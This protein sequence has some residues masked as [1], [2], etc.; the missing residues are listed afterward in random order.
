[1]PFQ[2]PLYNAFRSIAIASL[3]AVALNA[4]VAAA[5]LN[6][7]VSDEAAK[8]DYASNYSGGSRISTGLLHND[9]NADVYVGHLG[10][11]LVDNAAT[12]ARPVIVG[13]GGK[14]LFVDSDVQ[15]GSAIALGSFFRFNFA[16]ANRFAVAGSVH[17][18]P[19]VI[20]F[21]DLTQY[22][23]YDIRAEY[24][25]LKNASIYLGYRNLEVEV[26]GAVDVELDDG[27]HFG[28]RFVF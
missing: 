13:L 2:T 21:N 24:E 23:E 26:D 9:E 1:M 18:A 8:I 20:A 19:D 5:E 12:E 17:Y 25:V 7:N 11:H 4:P 15:S 16:Q 3:L 6:F 14:L 28:M 10:L 27:L 22:I